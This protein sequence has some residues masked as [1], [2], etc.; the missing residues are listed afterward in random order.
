MTKQEA[1]QHFKTG[2]KLAEALGIT[3]Q[4]VYD[5][6]EKV[7]AVRQYQIEVLTEGKLKAERQNQAA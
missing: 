5:W 4:A 1:V 3:H 6:G 7:P 2:A